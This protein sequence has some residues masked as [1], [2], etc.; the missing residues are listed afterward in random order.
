MSAKSWKVPSRGMSL[1]PEPVKKK[2]LKVTKDISVVSC[3][4]KMNRFQ[5][6]CEAP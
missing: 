6:K 1:C 5:R 2:I 4:F 3:V